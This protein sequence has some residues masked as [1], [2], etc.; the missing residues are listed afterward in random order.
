MPEPTPIGPL[1]EPYRLL[2]A[3]LGES[4]AWRALV[5]AATAEAALARVHL[6]APDPPADGRG[7]EPGELVRPLAVL[8]PGPESWQLT[9]AGAG[10][11]NEF[12]AGGTLAVRF[13]LPVDPVNA[14]NERWA[15]VAARNQLGGVLS[16][17]RALSGTPGALNVSGIRILELARI[18]EAHAASEDDHW[19]ATVEI[20]WW[21]H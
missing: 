1:N 13:E 3:M 19:Q 9:G 16:D 5:G 20:Q 10:L 18:A 14:D 7:Y 15:E 2:R 6:Y 21:G 8:E 12:A 4:Q 17:L 11:R